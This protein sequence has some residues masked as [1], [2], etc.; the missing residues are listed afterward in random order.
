VDLTRVE[1]A[2]LMMTCSWPKQNGT[3][4]AVYVACDISDRKAL[5]LS[6]VPDGRST[7][8]VMHSLVLCDFKGSITKQHLI[9]CDPSLSIFSSL[10]C[11]SFQ[12]QPQNLEGESEVRCTERGTLKGLYEGPL[13]LPLDNCAITHQVLS[14][15]RSFDRTPGPPAL[16]KGSA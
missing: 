14:I 13:N 7:R 8:M 2:H 16:L 3:L 12:N 15:L 5:S 9:S 10:L 11:Y 1:S 6:C 4:A